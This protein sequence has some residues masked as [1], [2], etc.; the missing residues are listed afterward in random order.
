[1]STKTL[2][3]IVQN[4]KYVFVE[5]QLAIHSASV[6]AIWPPVEIP[7]MDC[8]HPENQIVYN[9]EGFGVCQICG[10]R[11]IATGWAVLV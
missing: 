5:D 7:P 2:F 8:D 9:S 11:M 6:D 4:G 10:T 1:M 3:G